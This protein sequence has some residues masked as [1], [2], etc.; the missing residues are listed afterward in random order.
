LFG[1]CWQESGPYPALP[2]HNNIFE[3][4]NYLANY[5]DIAQWARAAE[6]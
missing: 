4:Y 5:V 2:C 1:A 6:A 3:E